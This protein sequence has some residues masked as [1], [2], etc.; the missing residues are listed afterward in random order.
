[1][2]VR[3]LLLEARTS[4]HQAALLTDNVLPHAGAAEELEKWRQGESESYIHHA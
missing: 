4:H 3:L 2:K 1:M